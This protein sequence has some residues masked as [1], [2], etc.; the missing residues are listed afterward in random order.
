MKEKEELI[1][2]LEHELQWV[3]YRQKMLDIIEEKLLKMKEI[4]ELTKQSN[5]TLYE[6]EALNTKINNLAEQVRALDG[7]SKIMKDD[8]IL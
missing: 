6:L 1:K 2:E 3:K 5:I 4:T 8:K 7:E